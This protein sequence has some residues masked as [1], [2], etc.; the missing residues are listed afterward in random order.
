MR[1]DRVALKGF[2]SHADTDF[3]PN[4]ARLV[5]IVGRNGAGKSALVVDPLLYSLFDDARGRTDDLVS[6]GETAMSARIEVLFDGQHYAIERGRTTRAGGKSYL[7]LAVRDGDAWRPLTGDTI[8]DTEARIRSIFRMDARAF[9][10]AV[11][12]GQGRAMAFAE[13]TAGDRKQIL[14]QIIDLE[15]Y[16]RAAARCREDARELEGRTNEQTERIRQLADALEL[17]RDVDEVLAGR[18]GELARLIEDLAGLERD[19]TAAA[20][21]IQQ[22]AAEIATSAA[23][24]ADVTRLEA[25]RTSLAERYRREQA[26][27]VGAKEAVAAAER[28]LAGE[29]EI[30][31]A[32]EDLPVVQRELVELERAEVEDRRIV[33]ELQTAQAE[34][35]ALERPY[36]RDHAGWQARHEAAIAKA[37][38]LEHA[39]R[40]GTSICESCGQPIG[41]ATALEQLRIAR[42][43]RG[44][45][46]AEEPKRPL[47]IDR[48]RAAIARLEAKRPKVDHQAIGALRRRELELARKTAGVDGIDAARASLEAATAARKEAEGA[49]ASV[50]AAGETTAQQLEQAR[51]K[52]AGLGPLREREALVRRQQE[53]RRGLVEVRSEQ[54]RQVEHAIAQAEA[55]V[56]RRDELTAEREAL[57]VT[58]DTAEADR[59]DLRE[60]S[61]AFGVKI[62]ARLIES[63]IPELEGYAN[64]LLA[65]LRPGMDLSIRAQRAKKDGKGLIEALDLVV[66]DAAGERPLAM[67]S[68]GERMS[69]SLAIA[70]AM[71]RLVARRAGAA[72][73]TLVVDE[74]DGLDADARRAF[75]QALRVLA[76]QGELERV[77][78]V[79]H[80]ED[81]AEYGDATYRVTKNGHGSVLEQV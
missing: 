31:K 39:G 2:L 40:A 52:V 22:L 12:L 78:L 64:Q 38:E 15:I 16:G 66:R 26:T 21:E 43:A 37:Y 65:E 33:A 71:S 11:V 77:V 6:L 47:S 60:L 74:P 19:T 27:I 69:V 42:S 79:S 50:Q 58:R 14:G 41:E 3:E 32:L 49:L 36:E 51:A 67:F 54:R 72:I 13:S 7:E 63:V 35:D 45:I 20:A 1:L 59:A 73:R 57:I 75:G 44:G 25:E 68:G 56:A 81:L 4:G 61:T 34:L 29:A 18:Q 30:R 53:S 8:K 76:H 24:E 48:G 23:A 5:T 17:L 46:A 10:T 62:P 80:H 28:V 70:V 55:N 9:E